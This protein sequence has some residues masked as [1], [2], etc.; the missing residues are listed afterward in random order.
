MVKFGIEKGLSCLRPRIGIASSYYALRKWEGKT[1]MAVRNSRVAHGLTSA[2]MGS[3][4]EDRR[5]LDDLF[6]VTYEELRR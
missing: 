1:V 5:A 6:S 3:P 4:N 2:E